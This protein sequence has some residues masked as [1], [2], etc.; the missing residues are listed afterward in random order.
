MTNLKQFLTEA[1]AAPEFAKY[2]KSA[3][4]KVRNDLAGYFRHKPAPKLEVVVTSPYEARMT[5]EFQNVLDP[6]SIDYADEDFKDALKRADVNGHIHKLEVGNATGSE[7]VEA[8]LSGLKPGMMVKA[9]AFFPTLEWV[10]TF[11]QIVSRKG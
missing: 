6:K 4:K 9:D 10:I 5:I 11:K 2:L 3:E 7:F 1:D 8:I